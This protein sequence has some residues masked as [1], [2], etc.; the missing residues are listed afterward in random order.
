MSDVMIT[1]D[2]EHK[3]IMEVAELADELAFWKFQAIWH[4]AYT[5]GIIDPDNEKNGQQLK[6]VEEQLTT[7]WH[8][9]L[10]ERGYPPR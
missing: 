8:K 1:S 7:F 6:A 2:R 9:D 10:E 3:L 5:Q 4:R